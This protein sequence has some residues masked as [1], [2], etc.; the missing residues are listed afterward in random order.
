MYS[1]AS[2]ECH[3]PWERFLNIWDH[4]VSAPNH[5]KSCTKRDMGPK[6]ANHDF[7]ICYVSLCHQDTLTRK[8]ELSEIAPDSH[9]AQTTINPVR[10]RSPRDT[11]CDTCVSHLAFTRLRAHDAIATLHGNAYFNRRDPNIR[12]VTFKSSKPFK[13][14][15]FKHLKDPK[16]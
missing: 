1:S 2:S 14:N 8:V 7:P 5:Y 16:R 3:A 4:I 12:T 6:D 9:G 10:E 11:S 15:T 13:T